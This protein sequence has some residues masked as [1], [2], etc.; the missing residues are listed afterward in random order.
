MSEWI[1]VSL[2]QF[3]ETGEGTLAAFCYPCSKLHWLPYEE[4]KL[5]FFEIT[6]CCLSEPTSEKK[7]KRKKGR[8][9]EKETMRKKTTF[10]CHLDLSQR[11][12]LYFFPPPPA[13]GGQIARPDEPEQVL[14][15]V[16]RSMQSPC[17]P[18]GLLLT[19]SAS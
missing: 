19:R 1:K 13:K 4:T 14:A 6:R 8:K 5:S 2:N 16:F 18:E 3:L 12:H 7:K 11:F 17:P 15:V 9:K 10:L